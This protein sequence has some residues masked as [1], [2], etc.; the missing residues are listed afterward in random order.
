M[1]VYVVLTGEVFDELYLEGIFATLESAKTF[2]DTKYKQAVDEN[3]LKP[4][5]GDGVWEQLKINNEWLIQHGFEPY[6]EWQMR[7]GGE[8]YQR[9]Y[10]REVQP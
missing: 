7:L 2:G 3:E 6:A 9:I 5:A 4:E 1:K 10:E 8:C